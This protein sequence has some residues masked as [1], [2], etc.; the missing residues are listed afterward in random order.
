M[1]WKNSAIL[2]TLF[3]VACGAFVFLVF[4]NNGVKLVEA[5][6]REHEAVLA[7]NRKME[8]E[9]AEMA[10]T[11]QRLKEDPFFVEFVA[12]QEYGLTGPDDMVFTFDR[13]RTGKPVWPEERAADE[14][15]RV[16]EARKL[17]REQEEGHKPEAKKPEKSEG[18]TKKSGGKKTEKPENKKDRKKKE[19]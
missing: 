5:K 18:S 3:A 15:R 11:I 6:R 2:A 19:T 12:R 7:A 17:K 14:A 1:G 8:E 13:T 4:S 16:E 9:N 10:R